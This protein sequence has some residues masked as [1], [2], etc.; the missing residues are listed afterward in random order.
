MFFMIAQLCLKIHLRTS[1]ERQRSRTRQFPFGCFSIS[2]IV[3]H[4]N[5]KKKEKLALMV[6]SAAANV[7]CHLADITN[8]L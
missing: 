7:N 5:K 6:L 1:E 8:A 3:R 4:S 2:E